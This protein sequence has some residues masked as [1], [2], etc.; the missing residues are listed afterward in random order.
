LKPLVTIITP[1][2]GA[3]YLGQCVASV[4]K[5]SYRNFQHL[6]VVDGKQHEGKV[7]EI[8]SK[9]TTQNVDL[10]LLPY[11]TGTD[12]YNGHRIYGA[13]TYL[14][15]GDH[16][17]FLDEDNW[18]DADHVESLIKIAT[19]GGDGLIHSARSSIRTVDKS[20]MTI[21]SPWVCGS[22]ALVTILSMWDVI[23]YRSS[24]RCNYRPSG[25][26]RLGKL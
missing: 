13:M 6:V 8:L 18:L 1:T 20:A 24:L 10:M 26:G 15:K 19:R 2:T 11:A 17:C 21:A 23:F 22:R 16:I 3:G 25:I 7:T 12:R 9:A 4:Q 14:C 5:Q